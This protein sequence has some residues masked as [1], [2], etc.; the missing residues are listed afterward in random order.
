MCVI[1]VR[2]PGINIQSSILRLCF[3][4]NDDGAGF[5]YALNKRLY[6]EKGFFTFANFMNAYARVPDNV[7]CVLHFRLATSG[8]HDWNNCH[9]HKINRGLAFVHNGIIQTSSIRNRTDS[10]TVWFNKEVLQKMPSNFHMRHDI[11]RA[12]EG[13]IGP[14]NKLVVL[15]RFGQITFFNTDGFDEYMGCWFSNFH[16]RRPLF[17]STGHRKLWCP[18]CLSEYSCRAEDFNIMQVCNCGSPL[19]K[20]GNEYAYEGDYEYQRMF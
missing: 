7:L 14:Y 1:V 3:D 11:V 5:M 13:M 10:D 19:E 9:P 20:I 12:I 6:I 4:A 16:W 2:P 8:L 15:D 18:S 17:E